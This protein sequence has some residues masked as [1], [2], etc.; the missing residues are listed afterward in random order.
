[1]CFQL[2]ERRKT[3]GP[4]NISDSISP[5]VCKTAYDHSQTH[6]HTHTV[7]YDPLRWHVFV[8]VF[9]QTDE[10]KKSDDL[11]YYSLLA[12]K[13]CQ[14]SFCTQIHLDEG[15]WY[16]GLSQKVTV[17]LHMNIQGSTIYQYL[18]T[19]DHSAWRWIWP[20]VKKRVSY[21]TFCRT[22]LQRSA[23]CKHTFIA[24]SQQIIHHS[25]VCLC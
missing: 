15:Q 12:V 22:V 5:L 1:M 18:Q 23:H 3:R 2:I 17:Y 21:Q 8:F 11:C 9:V 16:Y 13:V 4:V 20:A 25:H 10:L 14:G 19:E 6:T 7:D 24:E